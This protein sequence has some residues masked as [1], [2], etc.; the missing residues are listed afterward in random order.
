[1]V[2]WSCCA[3]LCGLCIILFPKKKKGKTFLRCKWVVKGE[4]QQRAQAATQT[5]STARPHASI[6]HH[7]TTGH[8]TGE[9]STTTHH[10]TPW[11]ML[12]LSD[13]HTASGVKYRGNAIMIIYVSHAMCQVLFP[14]VVRS[15]PGLI[16]SFSRVF[17]GDSRGWTCHACCHA[18]PRV[19]TPHQQHCSCLELSFLK[20]ILAP[21]GHV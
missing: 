9:H 12:L 15:L 17:I 16:A 7:S 8:N 14:I 10:T 3:R 4:K 6:Q 21:C 2:S 13:R 11:C 1:M 5:D 19:H 20:F 18:L